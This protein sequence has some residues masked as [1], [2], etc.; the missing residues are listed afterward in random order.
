MSLAPLRLSRRMCK[1]ADPNT[2]ADKLRQMWCISGGF[3]SQPP[4]ISCVPPPGPAQVGDVLA[5][6]LMRPV[7][8]SD[9]WDRTWPLDGSGFPVWA[10]GPVSEGSTADKPV[11]LYHRFQAR[12]P[13]FLYLQGSGCAQGSRA[14]G[15]RLPCALLSPAPPPP[16][17]PQNPAAAARHRVRRDHPCPRGPGLPHQPGSA[18]SALQLRAPAGSCQHDA[19][20]GACRRGRRRRSG[21]RGPHGGNPQG[22]AA[23]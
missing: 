23:V 13:A 8:A 15:C 21:A 11:V 6:M 16:P 20:A 18:V 1:A 19:C 22:G 10:M 4:L 2:L 7:A 12:S 3:S 14:H 17:P 5:V 9:V